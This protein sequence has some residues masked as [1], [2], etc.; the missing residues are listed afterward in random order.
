MS[1]RGSILQDYGNYH[2]LTFEGIDKGAQLLEDQNEFNKKLA[3]Q[4]SKDAVDKK[5]ASQLETNKFISGLGLDHIGDDTADVL[6][7]KQVQ[8]VQSKLMDMQAK[9][10][11]I[12][13]IRME[14]QRTLP[15]MVNA[16]TALKDKYNEFKTGLTELGKK[17]PTADLDAARTIGVT[18]MLKDALQY[19]DKGNLTGYKDPTIVPKKDY[20]SQ[21]ESN[22]DGW[23]QQSGSVAKG[24]QGLPM[25]NYSDVIESRNGKWETIKN[26][27]SGQLNA[28]TQVDQHPDTKEPTGISVKS[29]PITIGQNSDGTP[30]TIHVLPQ[31]EFNLL[32]DTP[33][34]K[35]DFQLMYNQHLKDLKIDPNSL[36]PRANDIYQR[37]FAKNWLEE[38]RLHGG[39]LN[40]EKLDNLPLP[41]KISVKVNTGA[42]DVPV[43]DV[44][45]P[46]KAKVDEYF[47][48]QK[49][50]EPIK[51]QAR[52]NT[53]VYGAVR[54]NDL[55]DKQQDAVL[56][57]AKSKDESIKNID[58][59]YLKK[60][61]DGGVGIVRVSDDRLITTLTPTGANIQANQSIGV[62]SKQKAV[63]QAQGKQSNKP[64]PNTADNL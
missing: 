3:Y 12:Q 23:Y 11:D 18:N 44:Y 13:A 49:N 34:K 16:H 37:S 53:L 45:T 7:D 9:G 36:D 55:D 57:A 59:I 33:Q 32:T 46:I 42:K 48:N 8:G 14:A 51:S 41:A 64:L 28:Y 5:A 40:K 10:A 2:P 15:Q 31:N 22:P 24:V 58:Q 43:I 35:L 38:T 30:N 29:E 1:H 62:K 20:V 60:T 39:L 27:Y 52:D 21:L 56:T 50:Y 47:T 4:K 54:G 25:T 19:D 17:Y 61:S 6:F 63:S 26:K